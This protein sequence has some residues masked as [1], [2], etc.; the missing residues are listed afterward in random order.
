MHEFGSKEAVP[1]A[2]KLSLS[3]EEAS[4]LTGIGLTSIRQAVNRE[5][6]VARK[7]GTRTII[8]RE[9]LEAWLKTLPKAGKK[10]VSATR[11]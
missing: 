8:L 3:T 9:E 11:D 2:D 1:I 7:H 5:A 4:A 10:S 6:L